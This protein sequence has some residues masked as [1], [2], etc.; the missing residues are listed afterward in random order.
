MKY[1]QTYV[2]ANKQEFKEKVR[3]PR[4]IYFQDKRTSVTTVI[5]TKK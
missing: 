3:K 4:F 5:V 1:T 2:M